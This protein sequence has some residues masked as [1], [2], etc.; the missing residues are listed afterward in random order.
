MGVF[1]LHSPLNCGFKAGLRGLTYAIS[2]V[3]L[4][5]NANN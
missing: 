5:K 4:N 2:L 3:K 1:V